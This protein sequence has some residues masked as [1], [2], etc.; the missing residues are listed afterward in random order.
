MSLGKALVIGLGKIGLTYDIDTDGHVL[1]DQVMT[2]CRAIS[3]S[4]DFELAYVV[5]PDKKATN[6]A[7]RI[8]GVDSAQSLDRVPKSLN[9]ELVVISV[10]TALHLETAIHLLN[11]WTP[12]V[13]LLEKPVGLSSFQAEKISNAITSAKVNVYVN[14]LRRYL[15]HFIE[16]RASTYF[17]ERGSVKRVKIVG[18]GSL[19]NIFSHFLDLLIFFEG[20]SVLDSS[21]IFLKKETLNSTVLENVHSGI[22]FEFNGISN[23]PTTCSM[24]IVYDFVRVSIQ[25]NGQVIQLTN[26]IGAIVVSYQLDQKS[27]NSYQLNVLD[28][29][30][31]DLG[32]S[33]IVNSIPG[34]IQIHRFIESIR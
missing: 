7:S 18:Y 27:F 17:Q 5:D 16:F 15:P 28:Q 19:T 24:E 29:I 32:Q 9:P 3:L 25:S 8:Y 30:S 6:A 26:S 23:Q 22:V 33:R 1:Q 20:E 21:G 11:Y 10:P 13:I 4:K 34:A 31:L 14:F 12:K 2:H